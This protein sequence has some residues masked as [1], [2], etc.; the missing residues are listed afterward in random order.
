MK[1]IRGI[2]RALLF[3]LIL[4]GLVPDSF[5]LDRPTGTPVL[6][7]SGM[8]ATSNVDG[9]AVFDLAMLRTLPVTGIRTATP[10]DK[11][12]HHFEGVSGADL[13]R[14]LGASG[15]EFHV[16]ALNNYEAVIPFSDFARYGVIFA[17]LK[18]GAPMSV[19]DKG[20]IF[21]VYPFD[22]DPALNREDILARSV[23]QVKSLE[24]R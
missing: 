18:D 9:S 7:V 17:Y 24:A 21:V 16:V 4:S 22:S 8:I 15:T 19:R 20:P 5:A 3:G 2:A 1:T 6:T 10:W 14:A 13:V 23:W 12:V 11:G